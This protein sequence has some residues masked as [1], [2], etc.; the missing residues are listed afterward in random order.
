MVETYIRKPKFIRFKEMWIVSK[1]TFR[2]LKHNYYL[3]VRGLNGK[4]YRSPGFNTLERLDT[5]LLKAGKEQKVSSK[6]FNECDEF[7]VDVFD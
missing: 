4:T 3:A 6:S 2:D 5:L 7:G 1:D